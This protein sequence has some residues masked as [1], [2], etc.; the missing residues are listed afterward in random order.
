MTVIDRLLLP[1]SLLTLGAIFLLLLFSAFFS[2]SETALTASSRAT[3][4]RLQEDGSAA[5]ARV[6]RLKERP[7]RLIGAIL[8]GNNLVNI[9]ASAL[10]TALFLSLFGEVG[11]AIAT[12]VMTLVVLI[13]AEIL[14]KTIAI[15]RTNRLAMLVAP[16]VSMFVVIFAPVVDVIQIG[17]RRL[18]HLFGVD[19]AA[20]EEV[21]SAH[22]RLRGEIE[23]HHKE[24]EV[25][26]GHRDMLGG[27]LDLQELEVADVMIHRK[28]ME[29][30]D[31]G[32]PND[33]IVQ[34]VLKSAHTRLPLWREEPENIIGVL[35][36]KD[37][38]RALNRT[39]WD[40]S[41]LDVDAVANEPW[42][43]P[44]TTELNDQLNAFLR[45][46]THFALVVDEYGVLMG[47]VT[48][49]DILEEIV[50]DIRDEYDLAVTGVRPQAD[51]SFNVDG[52]VP[53][54]DLNRALDWDLPDEE[55]TTIAGLVIHEAQTIPE[56]GQVFAFYGYKF[57][58]LRRHRNQVTALRI[59]A[60]R[61]KP[62]EGD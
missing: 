10:A 55:A 58:I 8:L 35:H 49:E 30:I 56:P 5:A 24:G 25:V 13:F 18:V 17:V 26:K 62:G 1:E 15:A 47:L 27:I 2:G 46:R 38:L 45:E 48:L 31:A 57:E 6:N 22:E 53:I 52:S 29:M 50:G 23:L 61:P 32:Q 4:H 39:G 43:V 40:A 3:M 11:V 34:E 28:S 44:E 19:I 60:P 20:G 7:E 36:Q 42:F 41:K 51:G 12:L 14:P 37:L 59:I 33:I 54:R 9:F 21:L 16:A